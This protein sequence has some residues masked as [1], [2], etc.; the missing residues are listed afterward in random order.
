MILN[1]HN[2]VKN[3]YHE[4]QS[5]EQS[6][7]YMKQCENILR[8]VSSTWRD[9][10]CSLLQQN[11]TLASCLN[12]ISHKPLHRKSELL[13]FYIEKAKNRKFWTLF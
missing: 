6:G 7:Q 11:N 9:P 8:C 12:D 2:A 10:A 1:S 4:G 5:F 13:L 3:F